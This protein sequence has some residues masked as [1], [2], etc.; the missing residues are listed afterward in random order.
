[1]EMETEIYNIGIQYTYTVVRNR[2]TNEFPPFPSLYFAVGNKF[3]FSSDLKDIDR[4]CALNKMESL[5][6]L[7]ICLLLISADIS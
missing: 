2:L 7:I 5:F 6:D 3:I 4:T 1:M